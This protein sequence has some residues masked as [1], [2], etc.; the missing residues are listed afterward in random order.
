MNE[1]NWKYHFIH[2]TEFELGVFRQ[3]HLNCLVA[4]MIP[5]AFVIAQA[6]LT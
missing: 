4:H 5:D 1:D 2:T 3:I 6:E